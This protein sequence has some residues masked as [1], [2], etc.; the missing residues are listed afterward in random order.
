M[1]CEA[2]LPNGEQC[3]REVREG[4]NFCEY[5]SLPV[6]GVRGT[7]TVYDWDR[8][9][10]MKEIKERVVRHGDPTK[11]SLREEVGLIKFMLETVL[12]K[13]EDEDGLLQRSGEIIGLTQMVERMQNATIAIEK[14]TGNLMSREQGFE[15]AAKLL[16]TLVKELEKYQEAEIERINQLKDTLL[17]Y[18]LP[19]DVRMEIEAGLQPS[20]VTKLLE[21]ITDGF[22]QVFSSESQPA[23]DSNVSRLA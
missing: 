12:S 11:F 6:P 19:E 16:D 10:F 9:K 3:P 4:S 14:Q 1:L 5:H 20:N 7:V 22:T 2:M 8:T 17:S 21:V 13:I 23:V 18:E 15:F